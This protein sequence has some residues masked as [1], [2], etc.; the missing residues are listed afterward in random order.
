MDSKFSEYC[1]AIEGH[2]RK[3][4]MTE[5]EVVEFQ[6]GPIHVLPLSFAIL[7]FPPNAKHRM[8][9]Y[10]TRCMSQVEDVHPL[11]LHMFVKQREDAIAE[12]LVA[13]A[14]Y[15]RTGAS[16]G[17]GHSINFGRPWLGGSICDRGLISLPYLDGP[18]LEWLQI[19]GQR[20]RFLWLV[21]VTKSEIE[22]KMVAGLEALEEWFEQG[23]LD[24]LNPFRASIV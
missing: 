6:K 8:W 23:K 11:E 14:H 15:H 18:A 10:S 9:A 17:L 20:I 2:Y 19:K 16:L 4:W 12:L 21:P 22:F 3:C 5:P 7:R 24:Y 1:R 13:A